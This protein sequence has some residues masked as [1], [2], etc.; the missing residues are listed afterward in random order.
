M[1]PRSCRGL[2]RRGLA[3]LALASLIAA[4]AGCTPSAPSSV[5]TASSAQSPSPSAT[6]LITALI[7]QFRDDYSN[8]TI[9]LQLENNTSSSV[10]AVHAELADPRFGSGTAWEGSIDLLPGLPLSLPAR[11]APPICN[12]AGDGAPSVRVTLAS[13]RVLTIQASDPHAVLPRIRNTACFADLVDQSVSLQFED[14]LAGESGTSA[15]LELVVGPPSQQPG[16]QSSGPPVGS[17]TPSS[18]PVVKLVSVAGT[19]LLDSDPAAPW[20][21]DVVLSPGEPPIVLSVRPARCDPHVVAED[22]V[23]TLIPLTLEVAGQTGTL[24]VAA[25]AQLKAQVYAFVARACGWPP[26]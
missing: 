15:K 14:S 9:V 2:S 8:G 18:A 13:G 5:P 26:Q 11:L 10:T 19:P 17:G 4:A 20:P 3:L 16:Q 6:G 12:A 7:D 1:G 25:S 23:G 22:K 24:S 21:H